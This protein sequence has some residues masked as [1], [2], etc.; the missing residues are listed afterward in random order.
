MACEWMLTNG[1]K[2]SIAPTVTQKV[3][4]FA[5]DMK[6]MQG[7]AFSN[8]EQNA[9]LLD[10]ITVAVPALSTPEEHLV[11]FSVRLYET[12]RGNVPFALVLSLS[13]NIKHEPAF[14][15]EYMPYVLH[16]C[17][18]TPR[19]GAVPADMKPAGWTGLLN[20]AIQFEIDCC[21]PPISHSSFADAPA[22]TE[23][24]A[25][26]LKSMNT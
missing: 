6:R 8:A 16:S 14:A 11:A 17:G 9:L 21:H 15:D 20:A 19:G 24:F 13:I 22:T 3:I 12:T 5:A 23:I 2:D 7:F 1:A 18:P 26:L 4:T 25:R 10:T